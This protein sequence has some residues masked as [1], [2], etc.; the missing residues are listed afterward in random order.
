MLS[1]L[2]TDWMC[3]LTVCVRSLGE[4]SLVQEFVSVVLFSLPVFRMVVCWGMVTVLRLHLTQCMRLLQDW[5]WKELLR[6]VQLMARTHV[7]NF[8]SMFRIK[9]ITVRHPESEIYTDGMCELFLNVSIHWLR[10][11][12]SDS[13]FACYNF[14]L[15]SFWVSVNFFLSFCKL[16]GFTWCFRYIHRWYVLVCL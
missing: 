6:S 10:S 1:E 4:F 15:L 5:V 9:V 13:C 8:E 16:H 2:F 7:W 14:L 3:F 12:C 11:A